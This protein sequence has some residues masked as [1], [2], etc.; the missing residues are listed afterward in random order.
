LIKINLVREGRAAVRGA[1]AAPTSSAGGPTNLNGLLIVSLILLGIVGAGAYYFVK[2][3]QL[4]QTQALVSQRRD[5]AQKLEHII[6]EVEDFQR[7]KDSLEKRI[8]LINDLKRNQ[9]NPVKILDRIS[10]DLPDLVWLDT[11][12]LDGLVLK[13]DGRALNPNAVAN[14]V[15]NIKADPLFEEP[16]VRSVTQSQV[17]GGVNVYSY[18]MQVSLKAPPKPPEETAGAAATGTATG[19]AGTAPGSTGP[20]V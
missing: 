7:R 9:K 2:K 5:E 11:M 16:S 14:F 1:T 3:S 20:G 4:A 10:V 6:K 18:S 8:A 13:I 15:S 12:T 17:A 19:S